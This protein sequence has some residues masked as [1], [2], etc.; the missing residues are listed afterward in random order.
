MKS[1]CKRS[2]V[3]TR[4]N[5]LIWTIHVIEVQHPNRSIEVQH[6]IHLMME[7]SIHLM[8][9]HSLV[10]DFQGEQCIAKNVEND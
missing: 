4:F 3:L 2:D 10:V 6:S 7:R 1:G 5:R 8:M 9:H